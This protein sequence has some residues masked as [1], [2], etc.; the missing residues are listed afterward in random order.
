MFRGILDRNLLRI[1]PEYLRVLYEGSVSKKWTMVGEITRFPN[2]K[3]LGGDTVPTPET[4]S[5]GTTGDEDVLAMKDVMRTVFRSLDEMGG[6]FFDS[7]KRVE[8]RVRP[9][10]IYQEIPMNVIT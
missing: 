2:A 9:L 1:Q 6:V 8:L 3:Q 5:E 10:A 4:V 7:K